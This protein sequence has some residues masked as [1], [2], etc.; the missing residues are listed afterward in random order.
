MR[1]F[2]EFEPHMYEGFMEILAARGTDRFAEVLEA[3]YPRLKK[4]AIDYAVLEPASDRDRLAV[5]PVSMEWSDIG[6]WG[7]ITDAFPPDEEGN[8][9]EG[10]A[11]L[12]NSTNT[13]VWVKNPDRRLV[14][15]VGVEGLAIVETEDALLVVPRE[16]AAEVKELVG[17]LKESEEYRDLT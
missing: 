4:T 16:K 11:V 14:A 15:A 12:K 2:E 1:Q 5:L 9:A 10:P 17:M 7:S 13:T 6:S 8:L 3:K